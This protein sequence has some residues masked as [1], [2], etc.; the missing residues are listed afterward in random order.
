MDE[1]HNYIHLLNFVCRRNTNTDNT[2][3]VTVHAMKRWQT[4]TLC[5]FMKLQYTSNIQVWCDQ[6]IIIAM[7]YYLG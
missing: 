5:L 7:T 6:W 2:T 3:T 1:F 4:V